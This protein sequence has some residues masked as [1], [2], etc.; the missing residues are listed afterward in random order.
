MM[1]DAQAGMYGFNPAQENYLPPGLSPE[2]F[3]S[4][5]M[6]PKQRVAM[7][8]L[9]QQMGSQMKKMG[10]GVPFPGRKAPVQLDIY[11]KPLR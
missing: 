2:S 1:Y 9:A 5:G 11:G 4:T 10:G 7:A 3:P 8:M 6:D